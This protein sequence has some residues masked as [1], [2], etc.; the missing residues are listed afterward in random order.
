MMKKIRTYLAFLF[1]ILLFSQCGVGN[2]MITTKDGK[3]QF[4]KDAESKLRPYFAVEEIQLVPDI[5]SFKADSSFLKREIP[6]SQVKGYQAGLWKLWKGWWL[7]V[8]RDTYDEPKDFLDSLSQARG[9][10]LMWLKDQ[11]MKFRELRKGE[12]PA[13]G[14]PFLINLHGGGK[15]PYAKKAWDSKMNDSEW[16]SAYYLASKYA[17]GEPSYYFIPRMADDRIGR[18][19][20]HSQIKACQDV[21]K[22]AFVSGEVNPKKTYLLGISEGGYGTHRLAMFMPDYFAG[23]G[24]MA[25]AEPYHY[26]ENLRNVSFQMEVGELDRG[27]GR[28]KFA[29]RWQVA[30]DSLQKLSP[31]DFVHEI[32]IQKGRGH[33]IDYFPLVPR[34][35]KAERRT[36]PEHLTYTYHNMTPDYGEANYSQGVYYLDFRGLE[37]HKG[38]LKIDVQKAGNTYDIHLENK[39]V[40]GKI[41]LYLDRIDWGKAVI[42][43]LNGKEIFHKKVKANLNAMLSSLSLWGDPLRIFPAKLD[44]ALT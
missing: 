16:A 10:C 19:Y 3:V 1:V 42:V 21:I 13:E 23:F 28:N 6:L 14:Y 4:T 25:A 27:F 34:L 35:L 11:Q 30:L 44:F 26:A 33:G 29:K 22:F 31:K 5:W 32:N 39:G 41:G 2:R 38:E 24:V 37:H 8:K 18:W 12:K 17:K 15:N 40:T 9:E 7:D 43:K 20:L 36:Y